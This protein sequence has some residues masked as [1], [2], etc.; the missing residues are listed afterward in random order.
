MG[1][2]EPGHVEI[3]GQVWELFAQISRLLWEK[4]VFI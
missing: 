1:F 2:E 3:L 4:T